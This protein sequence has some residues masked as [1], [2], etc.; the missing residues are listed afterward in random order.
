MRFFV[1]VH[2]LMIDCHQPS[3]FKNLTAF[4]LDLLVFWKGLRT[5]NLFA[6]CWLV[7]HVFRCKYGALY[8]LRWF[9][10]L[11]RSLGADLAKMAKNV[12]CT[13]NATTA[14]AWG[15]HGRHL[16]C[17]KSFHSSQ[18]SWRGHSRY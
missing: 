11:K 3:A 16:G 4:D 13:E 5:S 2:A 15:S 10:M 17:F 6:F 9:V 7:M 12:K 18:Q 1:I 8:C 14:K